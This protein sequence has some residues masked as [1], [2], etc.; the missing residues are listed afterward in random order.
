MFNFKKITLLKFT[1][2]GIIFTVITGTLLHFVYDLSNGNPVVGLFAPT[3][4][5]VWEHLKL[6]FYPA[7]LW[8]IIGYRKF[9]KNNCNYLFPT[10]LGVV[11]GLI[12][13][14]VLFYLYTFILK[15]DILVLDILIFIIGVIVCFSVFYFTQKNYNFCFTSN[16]K[17]ILLWEIVFI[18]FV[19]FTVYPPALPLFK[20]YS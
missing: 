2:L 15:K 6:L 3:N 11:S 10:F 1:I 5:S 19:L 14:P 7:T 18:L 20:D 16:K 9:G 13:I 8:I 17:V 4:E 12:T